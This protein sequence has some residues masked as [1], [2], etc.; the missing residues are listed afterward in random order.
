MVRV[1][2][3]SIIL[4]IVAVLAATVVAEDIV[5][6]VPKTIVSIAPRANVPHQKNPSYP[7]GGVYDG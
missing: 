4:A 1:A 6:I 3:N 7:G 5:T 2:P